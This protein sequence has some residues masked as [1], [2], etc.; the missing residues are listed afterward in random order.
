M[1]HYKLSD[2]CET[3][4]KLLSNGE[5]TLCDKCFRAEFKETWPEKTRPSESDDDEELDYELQGSL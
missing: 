3:C 1:S 2:Y 4:G 5:T